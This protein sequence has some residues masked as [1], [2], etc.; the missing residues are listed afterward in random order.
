MSVGVLDKWM[1]GVNTY[2]YLLLQL[3]MSQT[4]FYC[5]YVEMH[6]KIRKYISVKY[7]S[8]PGNQTSIEINV[9]IRWSG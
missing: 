1:A 8:A 3:W 6:L 9:P 2:W 7:L 5:L 4:K